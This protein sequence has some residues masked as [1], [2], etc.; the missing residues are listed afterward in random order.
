[1]MLS[2][3]KSAFGG[4]DE[5]RFN[6]TVIVIVGP[7]CSGKTNLSLKLAQ[8]IPSEIISADSRQIYKYLDIGTAKPSK[9]QFEKVTH[10]LIDILDPSENYDVSIFEKDAENIIEE[11]FTQ[12]K[13]PIVV[14]GSGLYIKA[15]IDGI[16]EVSVPSGETADK[17]VE[18]SS[19]RDGDEE[20]RKELHQKRKEFG[21]EFLYEELKKVDLVSAEKMLPQN[22][23]RVMRALEVFHTTREPIWKHHEKQSTEKEKKYLFKQYGLNWERE[24]LYKNIDNRVDE[25]IENGFVD[26]VKNILSMGYDKNLNSLNTVGYKEIIQYLEEEITLDRAIELIKRNTRHYAKRQLT[27][28]R[29]DKRIQWFDIKNI[30]QLDNIAEEIIHSLD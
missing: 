3:A 7:T 4:E 17:S 15:L 9:S 26:E 30:S 6:S 23:K 28:F 8:T 25:I 14:G 19:H 29:K 11:I 20:Y 24:V 5:K 27:W 13:I 22:W 21:N 10:H 1:M 16:F 2:I 18:T 12:D